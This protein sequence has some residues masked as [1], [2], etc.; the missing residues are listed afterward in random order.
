MKSKAKKLSLNRDTL[1][2]LAAPALAAVAGGA[3]GTAVCSNY[4][5]CN[6]TN[7]ANCTVTCAT[8]NTCLTCQGC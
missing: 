6:Y 8:C 7:C 3:K 4:V 2:D 5:T 1:R